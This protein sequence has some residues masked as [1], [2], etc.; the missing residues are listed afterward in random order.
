MKQAVRESVQRRR[1]SDCDDERRVSLGSHIESKSVQRTVESRLCVLALR[2]A[3][4][5]GEDLADLVE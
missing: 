2:A 1:R 4:L 3:D 5:G